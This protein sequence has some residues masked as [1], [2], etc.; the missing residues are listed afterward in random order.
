MGNSVF[1]T[2]VPLESKEI[3]H[4]VELKKAKLW[5]AKEQRRLEA[6]AIQQYAQSLQCQ[7]MNYE[8]GYHAT[9]RDV[10]GEVVTRLHEEQHLTDVPRGDPSLSSPRLSSLD[11]LR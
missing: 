10:L 4:A 9:S 5:D 6:E 1:E 11:S 2:T 8:E 3:V 7:Q